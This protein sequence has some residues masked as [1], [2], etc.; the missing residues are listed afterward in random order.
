MAPSLTSVERAMSR[1]F[2]ELDGIGSACALIGGLAVSARVDP[3]TTR[4]VDIAIFGRGQSDVLAELVFESL[5][6]D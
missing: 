1:I 5:Y 3:R 4:D 6:P 2:A